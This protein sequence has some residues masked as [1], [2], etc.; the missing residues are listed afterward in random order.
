MTNLDACTP[1]ETEEDYNAKN[2]QLL[3]DNKFFQTMHK[4][5][6]A[7]ISELVID[8]KGPIFGPFF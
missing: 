1:Q 4:L 6:C 3:H 7:G 5:G 2:K 8:A